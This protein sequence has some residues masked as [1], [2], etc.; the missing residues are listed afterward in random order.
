MNKVLS[1]EFPSQEHLNAFTGWMSNSG[2]QEF[3]EQ[4]GYEEGDD[5][6]LYQVSFDYSPYNKIIVNEDADE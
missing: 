6:K 1:I 3:W 5:K 4:E 2:E